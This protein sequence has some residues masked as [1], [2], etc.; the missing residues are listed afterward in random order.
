[1]SEDLINQIAE[2]L[3]IEI[4]KWEEADCEADA[5]EIEAKIDEWFENVKLS[6]R[7]KV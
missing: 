5:D 6:V 7:N 4:N 1:M 2:Q 3:L